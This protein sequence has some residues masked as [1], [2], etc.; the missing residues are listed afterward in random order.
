VSGTESVRA[1]SW[2]PSP[3]SAGVAGLRVGAGER[4]RTADLPFTRRPL[5]QLSYT[6]VDVLMLAETLADAPT[7]NSPGLP[8]HTQWQNM[9]RAWFELHKS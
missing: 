5:C 2:Q 9:Q 4:D 3:V 1:Q 6:G 7:G 8:W